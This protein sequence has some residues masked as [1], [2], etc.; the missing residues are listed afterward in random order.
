MSDITAEVWGERYRTSRETYVSLASRIK[1]LLGDV[2]GCEGIEV[3]QIECR[4]KEINS[5]IGKIQ[6][7]QGRYSDPLVDMTDLAA[8]RVIV[9]YLEDVARTCDIIEQEF[10]VD[11]DNSMDK[12]SALEV[13]RFGY[14]SVHYVV[15]VLKDRSKLREWQAYAGL[16]FEI[17]VR[18]VLQHAWAAVD[19]KLA[20]KT[21]SE[22]PA[23]LLR[24]LSRLSALF[25]LADEQFSA[26][27]DH[28]R[29]IEADYKNEVAV[30]NLDIPL[31]DL[32]L[33]AYLK[34]HPQI[35]VTREFLA[36]HGYSF[37]DDFSDIKNNN[38]RK[39][40]LRFLRGT[41]VSSLNEF[42][43]MLRKRLAGGPAREK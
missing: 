15:S 5:F 7:K 31:N 42:D 26:I 4:A 32:S 16:R 25:E 8:V 9:Y 41:G 36:R 40:L 13:D 30:G 1:G 28:S 23:S 3:V 19:H 35:D 2:L 43:Q 22:A 29:Q 6:R 11:W 39:D 18:T 34:S 14:S 10:E 33:Q 12:R 27:R 38:L 37:R 20:Y 24:Q 21:A 17:Q